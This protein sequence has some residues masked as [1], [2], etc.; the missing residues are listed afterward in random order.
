M[1]CDFNEFNREVC[2]GIQQLQKDRER[3]IIAIDG[4]SGA[5]KSTFGTELKNIFGGNLF[6]IDDFFL[7]RE[8]KTVERLAQPGGNFDRE[9]FLQTVLLPTFFGEPVEYR[10]YDCSAG[11]MTAPQYV[12]PQPITIIE[13]VYSLHPE[14]A[15]FYNLKIFLDIQEEEQLRRLAARN[16]EKL[17]DYQEQWIPMENRYFT[18]FSIPESCNYVFS[19]RHSGSRKV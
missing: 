12:I 4:C 11:Q 10:R 15:S 6:H 19:V 14:L 5:G 13:G 3:I 17:K 9:R 7:P 16:P 1:Y 2:T 18:A 8:R